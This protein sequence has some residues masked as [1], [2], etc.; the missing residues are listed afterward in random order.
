MRKLLLGG[1]DRA[2]ECSASYYRKVECGHP[3]V[4]PHALLMGEKFTFGSSVRYTCMGGRRLIGDATR[5]CQ[6]TSHWSGS[7]PHCS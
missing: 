5:T 6:L 2:L 4:P 7:L 3:G 1:S